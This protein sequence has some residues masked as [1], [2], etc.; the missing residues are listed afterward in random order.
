MIPIR[1]NNPRRTVPFVNVG[2]IIANLA[3]FAWELSLGFGLLPRIRW[4]AQKFAVPLSS[5]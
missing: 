4:R 3:M 2:L 1:D 5:G